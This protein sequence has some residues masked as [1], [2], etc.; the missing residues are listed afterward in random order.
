MRVSLSP[1]GFSPQVLAFVLVLVLLAGCG[2]SPAPQFLGAKRQEISLQGYD[3]AVFVKDDQAEVIRLG[4]LSKA[5]RQPVPA[6]MRAAAEQASG[7]KVTGPATGPFRSPALPG[8]TG[9][10]RFQLNCR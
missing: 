3:F 2:A 4:Y 8:D 5:E 9:E 7:C 10:A 6:L 1:A